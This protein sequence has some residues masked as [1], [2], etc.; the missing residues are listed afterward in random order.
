[1][2]KTLTTAAVLVAIAAALATVAAAR[3]A[4]K[5]ERVSIMH[6]GGSFVLTPRSSGAIQ[7]DKGT[8][9][10]CCWTA[11]HVVVAGER[12][13][14]DDPSLTLTGAHGTLK[15]HNRIEWVNV[16][17][18]LGIFTGT[19]K[20]VGGT[21]GYAGLSGGGRIAGVQTA[22]GYARA[23]FFGLLMPK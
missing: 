22:G 11:R 16:P 21:G 8:L 14:V 23:Q 10:A 17:G 15:L 5:A 1:M 4:S 18:G 20:V 9:S 13:E 19:W 3:P 6:K 2:R 7:A 12:L